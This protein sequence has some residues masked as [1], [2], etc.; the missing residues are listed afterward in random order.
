M[1]SNVDAPFEKKS[2]KKNRE[3]IRIVYSTHRHDP[4]FIAS[5]IHFP[6]TT[7][8]IQKRLYQ[9]QRALL[10]NVHLAIS[11]LI[12]FPQ[13]TVHEKRNLGETF[14]RYHL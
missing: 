11:L 13:S 5:Q 1:R 12:F 7:E 8:S 3:I 10:D 14:S 6:S 4:Q 2:G 9:Y